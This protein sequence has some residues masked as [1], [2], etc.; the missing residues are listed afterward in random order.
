MA[1]QGCLLCGLRRRLL[2]EQQDEGAPEDG[3]QEQGLRVQGLRG[4][5]SANDRLET[6]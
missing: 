4:G 1:H 3:P 5:I 6:A 2:R